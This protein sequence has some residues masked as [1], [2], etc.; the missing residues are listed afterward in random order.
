[1]PNTKYN[2]STNNC[3]AGNIANPEAVNFLPQLRMPPW[4]LIAITPDSHIT[5][6]TAHDVES[7]DAFIS[8]HVGKANL[9]YSVNPTKEAMNKKPA[10][11]GVIGRQLVDS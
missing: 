4:I 11:D 8:S 1:M 9:Y 5:A 6:I 7:A 3:T 10:K 2:T